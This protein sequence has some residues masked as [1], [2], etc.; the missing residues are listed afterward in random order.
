MKVVPV[1]VKPAIG[2]VWVSYFWTVPDGKQKSDF[3]SNSFQTFL[4]SFSYLKDGLTCTY[5]STDY[6]ECIQ[7][8]PL[9]CFRRLNTSVQTMTANLS[10]VQ[11]PASF[12]NFG[13]TTMNEFHNMPQL[14]KESMDI[15]DSRVSQISKN[16][17]W[18]LYMT[19]KEGK[20]FVTKR[21][22]ALNTSRWLRYIPQ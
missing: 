20:L 21:Q 15:I 13:N 19:L 3:I 22:E 12:S 4:M 7:K 8:A 2:N 17:H 18:N 9:Q 6:S 1:S 5:D 14:W 10:A 16:F 11:P